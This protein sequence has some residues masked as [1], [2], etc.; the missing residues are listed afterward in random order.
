MALMK[1]GGIPSGQNSQDRT[2][3]QG[4]GNVPPIC[5]P[6]GASWGLQTPQDVRQLQDLSWDSAGPGEGIELSPLAQCCSLESM[7]G[8]YLAASLPPDFPGPPLWDS[9][10]GSE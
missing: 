3:R 7:Q 1:T 6:N 10:Q 9:I 4:R 2:C 8:D 5:L